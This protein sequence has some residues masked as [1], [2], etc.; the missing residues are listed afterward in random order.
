MKEENEVTVE[1]SYTVEEL[2]SL[3]KKN[4]FKLKETYDV[5]DIYMIDKNY[6]KEKDHLKLLNHSLLLRHIILENK[7]KKLITKKEKVYNKQQE[8]IKQSKVDLK[9]QSLE[10]AKTFLEALNYQELI[11][12][13]DHLL[14]YANDEDELCIQIVNNKHI[15]IE[16]ESNCEFI[17][18]VYNTAKEM[19]EVFKKYDIKI[20]NNNYFAKKAEIE[21]IERGV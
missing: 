15:Y 16:I 9:V 4:N 18:K 13:N 10:E 14:V 20:K 2:K 19:K 12:I 3:L 21:L 11:R 6:L 7:E 8:I 5:N 17:D 1:I